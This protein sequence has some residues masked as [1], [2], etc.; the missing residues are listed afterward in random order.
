[1]RLALVLSLDVCFLFH[2]FFFTHPVLLSSPTFFIPLSLSFAFVLPSSL[3]P[4]FLQGGAMV[5]RTT[6]FLS[7]TSI[8]FFDHC[9]SIHILAIVIPLTFHLLDHLLSAFSIKFFTQL[10]FHLSLCLI[11]SS[12]SCLLP[13]QV[14][15]YIQL[16]TIP[17]HPLYLH[18]NI[19][20][21]SSCF[22]Y[23]FQQLTQFTMS[24][25]QF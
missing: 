15:W 16:S 22:G 9:S 19:Y 14:L 10:R 7:V 24:T 8:P 20:H 13:V 1:M 25:F 12:P 11:H 17:F 23:L 6:S 5:T 4:S 21:F 2:F 18:L 3:T